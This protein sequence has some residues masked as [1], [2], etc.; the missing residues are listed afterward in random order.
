M[1]GRC[2]PPGGRSTLG[3]AP[4]VLPALYPGTP[5]PLYDCITWDHARPG[6]VVDPWCFTDVGA[7]GGGRG[8]GGG[9]C[10]AVCV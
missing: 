2:V 9:L 1:V 6:E 10:V 7:G 5:I 4:C 3:G 8:G